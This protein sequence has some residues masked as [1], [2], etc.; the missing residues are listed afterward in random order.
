MLPQQALLRGGEKYAVGQHVHP[1][2]PAGQNPQR[3]LHPILRLHLLHTGEHR[4]FH[5]FVR[6]GQPEPETAAIG[7]IV[8]LDEGYLRMAGFSGLISREKGGRV[9]GEFLPG[10]DGV[11]SGLIQHIQPPAKIKGPFPEQGI[12]KIE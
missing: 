11:E 4:I 1:D 9:R 12:V 8:L 5:L 7:G 6:K 2:S 3:V 10:T